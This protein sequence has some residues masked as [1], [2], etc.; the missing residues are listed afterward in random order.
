VDV[1]AKFL[2]VRGPISSS[3]WTGSE[4]SSVHQPLS[5]LC[6]QQ[7][8]IGMALGGLVGDQQVDFRERGKGD[9]ASH[10]DF[11]MIGKHD[12]ACGAC[13][14]GAGDFGFVDNIAAG[15]VAECKPEG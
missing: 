1:R 2:W 8:V 11:G 9:A 15:A 6:L 10:T 7:G 14:H 12:P 5:E 3:E 13:E 4:R